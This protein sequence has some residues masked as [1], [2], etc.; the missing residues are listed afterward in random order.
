LHGETGYAIVETDALGN[1]VRRLKEVNPKSGEDL[2]LSIDI[3]LQE[4]ALEVMGANR[5]AIVAIDPN[6]GEVLA[7]VSTPTF[8]TN[9]LM[10]GLTN[11]LW[12]ALN[13]EAHPCKTEP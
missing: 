12:Q 4:A 13:N 1:P 5:G 10:A 2:K 3:R 8:D 6:N 7:M 11:A 9:W